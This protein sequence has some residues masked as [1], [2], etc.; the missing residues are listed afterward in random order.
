MLRAGCFFAMLCSLTALTG[1]TGA[2][3]QTANA[4]PDLIGADVLAIDGTAVGEVAAIT[5]GADGDFAKILVA[6]ESPLGIGKRIV[7]IPPTS[8]MIRRGAVVLDLSP[9]DVEALPT[10]Q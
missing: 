1:A 9:T 7:V 2:Q 8:F 4:V 6:V 10:S 3:S 5:M